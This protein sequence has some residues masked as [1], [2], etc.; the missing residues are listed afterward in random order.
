MATKDGKKS[1]GRKKGTPNLA[2]NEVIARAQEMGIDPL[3]ILLNFAAGRWEALGYN[4]PTRTVTTKEGPVEVDVISPE[5][6]QKSAKDVMP[7]MYPQLKAIEH[8]GDAANNFMQT[9]AQV[10]A[11]TVAKNNA[12]NG[13]SGSS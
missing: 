12:G 10:M 5:L 13:N 6:Q 11:S 7:F 1:G 8:K 3:G 9:L 4:S 2:S